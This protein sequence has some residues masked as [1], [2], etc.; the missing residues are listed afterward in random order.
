MP[1]GR[2]SR[3]RPHAFSTGLHQ[4]RDYGLQVASLVSVYSQGASMMIADKRCRMG[5]IE[6]ASIE[7]GV[8]W[9][10]EQKPSAAVV[11]VSFRSEMCE[12]GLRAF[13]PR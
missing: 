9:V 5:H 6:H 4:R 1:G 12:V 11:L 2:L 3:E 8:I 10:V 7:V 13:P